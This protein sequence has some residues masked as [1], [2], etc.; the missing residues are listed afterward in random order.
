M[1]ANGR[2]MGANGHQWMSNGRT[3]FYIILYNFASINIVPDC[4][5]VLNIRDVQIKL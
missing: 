1:G 5:F 4:A 3:M 2:P